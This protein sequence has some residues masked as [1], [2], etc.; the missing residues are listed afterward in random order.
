VRRLDPWLAA[1]L[2]LCG[3]FL[4]AA[5]T[6]I[7]SHHKSRSVLNVPDPAPHPL[8]RGPTEPARRLD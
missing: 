1:G 3:L 2:L 6:G 8:L 5:S 7:A 4:L